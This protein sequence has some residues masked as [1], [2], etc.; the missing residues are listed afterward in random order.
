MVI[1]ALDECDRE[2]DA[3]AIIRILSKAKEVTSVSLR[4]FITS[5]PELPIRYGFGEIQGEYQDMAL[6]RIPEP[7]VEHDIS[8]FL[9]Y[10]LARIRDGYNSQALEG[11]QLLLAWPSEDVIRILTQMAVPLF[12]FAATVCRFINDKGR[13]NPTKRLKKVL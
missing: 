11:L 4:F 10:K 5:R 6:H 12:I 13:S 1:D 8:A 2:E 7:V 9:R 3:I